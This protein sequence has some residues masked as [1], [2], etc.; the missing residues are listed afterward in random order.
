[1]RGDIDGEELACSGHRADDGNAG[2]EF[3][4]TA[5]AI[6]GLLR[7]VAEDEE[8]DRVEE[9]LEDGLVVYCRGHVGWGG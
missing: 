6:E 2:E 8:D 3:Q 7:L 4:S 9:K 1:M 5:G